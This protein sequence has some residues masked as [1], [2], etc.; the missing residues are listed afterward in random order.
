MTRDFRWLSI[1][2]FLIL[3]SCGHSLPEIDGVD[4]ASWKEDERGCTGTR[5]LT[6]QSLQSQKNK[7]LGLSEME[8]VGLLGRPDENE[9]YKRNQKFY[10]YFLEASPDC[11]SSTSEPLK[12]SIRFN[13]M[14]LAK[15]VAVAR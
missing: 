3:F 15:E 14:G 6:V 7:F 1:F 8:I 11:P 12:L 4:L 13:A 10:H 5:A 9:L 2:L